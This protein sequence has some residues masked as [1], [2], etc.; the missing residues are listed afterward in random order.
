MKGA[1]PARQWHGLL[2]AACSHVPAMEGP[3]HRLNC[4]GAVPRV[5]HG[6]WAG[7]DSSTGLPCPPSSSPSAPTCVE[8]HLGLVEVCGGA[9]DEDVPRIE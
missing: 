6:G 8:H 7:L 4:C 1:P 9:L 3:A 2:F 5:W